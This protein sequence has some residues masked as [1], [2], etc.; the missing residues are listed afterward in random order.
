[1]FTNEQIRKH[2]EGLV[3]QKGENH[4]SYGSYS[5]PSGKGECFLGALCEYMGFKV[6]EGGTPARYV[7]GKGLVT[8]RME[9]AFGIAQQLNDNRFEWKYVLM[10]VDLVLDGSE[11][12]GMDP[13]PCGCGLVNGQQTVLDKVKMRRNADK[14]AEFERGLAALDKPL[15]TGGYVQYTSAGE[16]A[17]SFNASGIAKS[18]T[19]MTL[20]I[21]SMN[22]SMAGLQTA[23]AQI[24][25][26]VDVTP[27]Q[28]DHALVA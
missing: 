22:A 2:M 1:M 17:A 21:N 19:N 14:N 26:K 24:N 9:T 8:P 15:A 6:P 3:Q 4:T 7:L 18:L 16:I 11:P 23:F 13:C 12:L 10:G 25:A 28:K 5:N 27:M 20:S